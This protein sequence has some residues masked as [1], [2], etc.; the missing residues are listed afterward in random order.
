MEKLNSLFPKFDEDKDEVALPVVCD[1]RLLANANVVMI[2]GESAIVPF[3]ADMKVKNFKAAVRK[4][5]GVDIEMQKL[6]YREQE[7]E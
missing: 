3:N 6:L 7:L 4:K 5:F 1:T 2:G